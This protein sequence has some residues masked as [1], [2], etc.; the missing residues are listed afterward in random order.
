MLAL[1]MLTVLIVP[2]VLG[3]LYEPLGWLALFVLPFVFAV[4]EEKKK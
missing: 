4:G 1:K 2:V 3:V